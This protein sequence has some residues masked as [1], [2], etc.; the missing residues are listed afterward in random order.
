MDI[1]GLDA[2]EAVLE[3]RRVE[4]DLELLALEVHRQ[5]LDRLAD[6]RRLGR[7]RQRSVL[8]AHPQWAVALRHQADP[9]HHTGQLWAR[10][11]DLV[12]EGIGQQPLVVRELTID[13]AR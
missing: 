9:P 11:A 6:I 2:L 8:E 3:E 1:V 13:Q 4:P 5:A 12:L 10:N 7:D